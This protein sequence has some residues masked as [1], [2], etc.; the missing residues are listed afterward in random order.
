MLKVDGIFGPKT[1]ARVIMF[2]NQAGL[3]AD[4]LVGPFTN[5]A[6]VSAVLAA[7]AKGPQNNK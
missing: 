1:N 4:G 6:L 7:I 3:D 2:Q 5:K